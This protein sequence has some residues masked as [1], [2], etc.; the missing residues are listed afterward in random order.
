MEYGIQLVI[1]REQGVSLTRA[2]GAA[3]RVGADASMLGAGTILVDLVSGTQVAAERR[4]HSLLRDL[5]GA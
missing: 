4:L 2:I 3:A 5:N 1:A